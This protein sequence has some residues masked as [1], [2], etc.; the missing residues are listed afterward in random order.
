MGVSVS[1]ENALLFFLLNLGGKGKDFFSFFPGSQC[2]PFKFPMSPI[3][4]PI[5][6]QNSKKIPQNVLHTTSL[7]SHML[8]QML[9]SFQLYSCAK[10]EKLNIAEKKF[11][12]GEPPQ[13]CFFLE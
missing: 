13:I 9:S 4:L 6:S 1:V 5:C 3:R 12:C 11:C 8:W 10:G 7:L 2:V